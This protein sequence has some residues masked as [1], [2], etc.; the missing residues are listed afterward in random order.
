LIAVLP[1]GTAHRA[2]TSLHG[3]A[4]GHHCSA[5]VEMSVEC[6]AV[7][8][9]QPQ[10]A[11]ADG[12]RLTQTVVSRQATSETDMQSRLSNPESET[13]EKTTPGQLAGVKSTSS[14]DAASHA[15]VTSV[16]TGSLLDRPSSLSTNGR[17]PV[18]LNGI[19]N[20]DKSADACSGT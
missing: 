17:P 10:A 14:L 16:F 7:R 11:A 9:F 6:P 19:S 12:G 1:A 20:T 4:A 13:L 18:K 8:E 3:H 5:V 15:A 2:G